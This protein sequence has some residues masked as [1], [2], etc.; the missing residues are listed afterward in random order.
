[1]KV[2]IIEDEKIAANKIKSIVSK[3]ITDVEILGCIETIDESVKFLQHHKPDL[4]FMD[5]EL[6]DGTSFEIFNLVQIECPIIFTTAYDKY[7]IKAFEVNSIDYLLK[8]ITE[9][10]MQRALDNYFEMREVF[11]HHYLKSA[12]SNLTSNIGQDHKT[13]FLVKSG[14]SLLPIISSNIA[15]FFASDKWTYLITNN[16]QR[17]ILNYTLSQLEELIDPADFKRINRSYLVN[18]GSILRL[19]VYLKGQVVAFIIPDPK[20]TIVVSRKQTPML[21]AWLGI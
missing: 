14:D 16:N 21:K 17:Y 19:E 7:A 1:M 13:S 10:A 12:L 4:I 3:L 2:L 6:A 15:Y 8:P 9:E 18:K 20:E 11:S 5:I